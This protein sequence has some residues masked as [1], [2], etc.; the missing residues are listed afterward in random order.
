M[1][2]RLLIVWGWTCSTNAGSDDVLGVFLALFVDF[3]LGWSWTQDGAVV[4]VSLP[5]LPVQL[6]VH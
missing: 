1:C 3:R 4:G 6:P 2:E 5:S